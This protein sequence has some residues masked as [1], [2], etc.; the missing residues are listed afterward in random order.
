MWI[1][2]HKA[3]Q[4]NDRDGGALQALDKQET[5]DKDGK[6]QGCI[7]CI[8]RWAL[9]SL[10]TLLLILSFLDSLN[11]SPQQAIKKSAG[12]FQ[13]HGTHGKFSSIFH[14]MWLSA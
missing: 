3:W 14:V 5:A 12:D 4:L 11:L 7:I 1:P 2:V 9:P 6:D 13:Q 10:Y 8:H